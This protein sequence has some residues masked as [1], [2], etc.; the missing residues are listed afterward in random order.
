ME[1]PRQTNALLSIL[2]ENYFRIQRLVLLAPSKGPAAEAAATR[3]VE[4]CEKMTKT[5]MFH[6]GELR[7]DMDAFNRA[8]REAHSEMLA[9]RKSR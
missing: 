8:V 7:R 2:M 1:W 6:M 5:R 4:S 9:W 3:I